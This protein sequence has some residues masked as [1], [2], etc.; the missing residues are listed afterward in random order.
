MIELIDL[1]IGL[2]ETFL[3]K[4]K[5]QLPVQV[6]EAVQAAIDALAAHHKDLVTKAALEAQRG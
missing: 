5:N 3:S 2:F 4:S 1:G 6:A